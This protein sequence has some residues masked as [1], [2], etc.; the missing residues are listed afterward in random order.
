VRHWDADARCLWIAARAWSGEPIEV[1]LELVHLDMR[2]PLPTGSGFFPLGSNGLASGNTL[3]EAVAHAAWELVERDAVALF[4][5][6]PPADQGARRLKL[7]SVEDPTCRS[8]L[9]RFEAAGVGVAIWDIT[10]DV[11]IATFLCSIVEREVDPFRRIGLARG[12]GCHGDREVALCRALCEAA[13]SRLTRITGSR[14]DIQAEDFDE[15]RTPESILRFQAQLREGAL[16][17]RRFEDIA[18][19]R[20]GSFEEDLD[21]TAECLRAA[22]LGDILYV[23]LSHHEFPLFVTR[24]VIEGLE[25]APQAPGYTPGIRAQVA[26]RGASS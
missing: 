5:A 11:G 14:D 1:P 3:A 12:Y 22:G 26:A 20:L 7:E 23:D 2:V 6:S 10:S 4:Y 9:D 18:S 24:V 16:A 21:R 25:G 19:H 15:I 8:L 13:Q 17:E